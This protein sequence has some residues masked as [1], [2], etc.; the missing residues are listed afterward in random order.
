MIVAQYVDSAPIREDADSKCAV[1]DAGGGRIQSA[2][3]GEKNKCAD[4][5]VNRTRC[6]S[7]MSTEF[8]AALNASV[9]RNLEYN[10]TRTI[11]ERCTGS[12]S[13]GIFSAR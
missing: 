13:F 7:R 1:S 2:G 9:H 10:S 12:Y 3:D 5:A 4:M 6:R 11:R 8:R